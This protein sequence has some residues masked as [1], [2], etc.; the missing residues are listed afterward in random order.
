MRRPTYHVALCALCLIPANPC[1]L[2]RNSSS[3]T[4]AAPPLPIQYKSTTSP[5]GSH[6]HF[7]LSLFFLTTPLQPILNLLSFVCVCVPLF[8]RVFDTPLLS[9]S[10]HSLRQH[11]TAA[12]LL[13]SFTLAI[14][15]TPPLFLTNAFLIFYSLFSSFTVLSSWLV[16]SSLSLLR[17]HLP[18]V[19]SQNNTHPFK[20]P[21][22]K[23]VALSAL[24]ATAASA[25]PSQPKLTERQMQYH[26]LANR[27]NSGAA[28][29]GL[30]DFDILQL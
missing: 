24:A 14:K 1:H 9:F 13:L 23:T 20:M 8:V 11:I 27:Q 19:S 18:K 6:Q 2:S 21:S 3:P 16:R 5:I 12:G 15:K 30:N 29:S 28:A 22:F 10:S 4:S 17:N 7:P 26:D 25:L